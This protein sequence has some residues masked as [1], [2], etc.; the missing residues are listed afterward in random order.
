MSNTFDTNQNKL[1]KNNFTMENNLDVLLKA[2]ENHLKEKKYL[3]KPV[4]TKKDKKGN[5]IK[6]NDG[7]DEFLI[8]SPTP[9]KNVMLSIAFNMALKNYSN[10]RPVHRD[11]NG[12]IASKC[13]ELALTEITDMYC[14]ISTISL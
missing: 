12:N 14:A 4:I 8:T 10:I 6:D 2:T 9:H 13:K 3:F 11:K 5:V 1:T 7:N